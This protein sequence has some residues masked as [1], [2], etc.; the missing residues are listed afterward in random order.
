[1]MSRQ[2]RQQLRQIER[3]IYESDPHWARLISGGWPSAY[4]RKRRKVNVLVD[5]VAVVLL[6]VGVLTGALVVIVAGVLCGIVAGR[7]HVSRRRRA[8]RPRLAN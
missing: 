1:M 8:S 3:G 6:L 4:E 5:V 7:L 2:E